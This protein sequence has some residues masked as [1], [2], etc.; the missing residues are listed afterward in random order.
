MVAVVLIVAGWWCVSRAAALVC[1]GGSDHCTTQH[2]LQT[3][4]QFFNN[5][6]FK[7][8]GPTFTLRD[9]GHLMSQQV[10]ELKKIVG[11][12][13]TLQKTPREGRQYYGATDYSGY[14]ASTGYPGY[15]VYNA[16]T[17]TTFNGLDAALSA[18]AFLAFGVWLFNLVMPQLQGA[19]LGLPGLRHKTALYGASAGEVDQVVQA[20]GIL[21]NILNNSQELVNKIFNKDGSR[22]SRLFLTQWLGEEMVNQGK[23]TVKSTLE[24]LVKSAMKAGRD[25]VSNLEKISSVPTLSGLVQQGSSVATDFIR[26]LSSVFQQSPFE[27]PK[28]PPVSVKFMDTPE[29]LGSPDGVSPRWRRRA[30][31]SEVRSVLEYLLTEAWRP[32]KYLLRLL[33]ELDG[34][35]TQHYFPKSRIPDTGKGNLNLDNNMAAYPSKSPVDHPHRNSL[36]DDGEES[37][38]RHAG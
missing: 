30:D 23:S 5:I 6:T 20:P 32:L 17:T 15:G 24:N 11:D 35:H 4:D 28:D 10:E 33:E 38:T 3:I 22:Q 12:R 13:L 19:G 8:S 26:K 36:D 29:A 25:I 9:I 31:N 27:V 14:Y 18:L 37:L 34:R 2:R 16:G 7:T 21:S 1:P